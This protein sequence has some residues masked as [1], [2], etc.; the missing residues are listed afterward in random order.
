MMDLREL[1][2]EV[3]K[4]PSIELNYKGLHEHWYRP[5][6]AFPGT[7]DHFMDKISAE[8]QKDVRKKMALL[9]PHLQQLKMSHVLHEKYHS[10]ARHLVELKLTTL[11]GDQKKGKMI[12]SALT[13]DDFLNLTNTIGQMKAFQLSM[14]AV[15]KGYQEIN[16]MVSKELSLEEALYF[17]D[18]PHKRY[19]ANLM[20]LSQDHSIIVRDLGRHFISLAK[21]TGLK[22]GVR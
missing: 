3:E 14:K 13:K 15:S 19:V 10:F 21:Q 8:T 7:K 5:L 11:N 4:L 6:T 16:E 18:L 9:Q 17:M 22:K 20:K 12:V 2:K 1:K